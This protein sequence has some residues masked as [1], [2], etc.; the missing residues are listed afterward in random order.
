MGFGIGNPSE[1]HRILKLIVVAQNSDEIWQIT[2]SLSNLPGDLSD[3][4]QYAKHTTIDI[5]IVEIA[6]Q[7]NCSNI[8][9][10]PLP[11]G[12]IN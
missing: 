2:A 10:R 12:L 8:H 6:A 7:R 5:R 3:K 11:K 9:S 4:N 1:A